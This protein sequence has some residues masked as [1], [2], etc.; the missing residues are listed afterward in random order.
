MKS[1]RIRIRM[2][3]AFNTEGNHA[4]QQ[5]LHRKRSAREYARTKQRGIVSL[6]N[7]LHPRITAGSVHDGSMKG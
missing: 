4:Q 7:D 2:D 3:Q 5:N 1:F 6:A